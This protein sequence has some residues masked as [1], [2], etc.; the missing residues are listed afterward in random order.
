MPSVKI[1][2][3]VTIGDRNFLGV[4]S[5]ILQQIKIGNDTV[6]GANS[7]IIRRTKDGMT[8]VGSPASIIK[9]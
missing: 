8:Y 9:Y 7:L 5:V 6:I 2:G 1:S 4:N 3:E